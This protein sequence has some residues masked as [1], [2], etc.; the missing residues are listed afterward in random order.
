MSAF[1]SGQGCNISPISDQLGD[2]MR[3]DLFDRVMQFGFRIL[4]WVER[5]YNRHTKFPRCRAAGTRII[6]LMVTTLK[7]A[8]P[9]LR[10]KN[11]III[12]YHPKI[13]GDAVVRELLLS[14]EFE[15]LQSRLIGELL[16]PAGVFLDIGANIGYFSILASKI[17][18]SQ[19][20]VYAF[21]PV[22]TTYECLLRNLVLNNATNVIAMNDACFSN[23][24]EMKMS[25][26]D[27]SG[28][29]C[30]SRGDSH[31]SDVTVSVTVTTLD[32]FLET[33]KLKRVDLIKIDTEGADV[34]VIV[35]AKQLIRKF[36]PPILLEID[37]LDRFSV[38]IEDLL[39][40]MN[41]FNYSTH[42]ERNQYSKDLVC[43]PNQTS[44]RI[45][46]LAT[47]R[48]KSMLVPHS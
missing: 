16:P 44:T 27:D 13:M 41:Q 21:E 24:G 37:H 36:R 6:R 3:Y 9:R 39:A 47:N 22:P 25:C 31:D 35:G 48:L 23:S 45:T 5:V 46:R 40:F 12:E 10:C 4:L 18:G 32:R 28:K 26:R 11:D 19:G 7:V 43:I 29:S 33:R 42:E 14:G 15:P 34:E 8:P 1:I 20:T 2:Q 30:L 17:V 38:E